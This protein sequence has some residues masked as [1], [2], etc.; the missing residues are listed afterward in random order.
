LALVDVV[1][2]TARGTPVHYV[3]TH[4]FLAHARSP[5]MGMWTRAV[6]EHRSEFPAYAAYDEAEREWLAR[7]RYRC[8]TG[9]VLDRVP[10]R[11]ATE[12]W[13]EVPRAERLRLLGEA[14]GVLA[15]VHELR[16]EEPAA[17]VRARRRRVAVGAGGDRDRGRSLPRSRP[18]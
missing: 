4:A 5:D 14:G 17:Q 18:A 2:V 9:L 7:G 10:G 11:P 6:E 15:R 1:A 3:E 13:A 12:V 8:S 16:V